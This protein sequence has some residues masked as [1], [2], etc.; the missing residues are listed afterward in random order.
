[1]E[2]L[3]KSHHDG[4]RRHRSE[5]VSL[6][7][8]ENQDKFKIYTELPPE[9]LRRPDVRI[10]VDYPEDLVVCRAV[11]EHFK[12]FA[13]NI[14]LLNVV[15]FLDKNKQLIKLTSSFCEDGYQKMYQ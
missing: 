3:K 15:N 2:A 6:F 7:I 8:H 13:P 12:E 4:D 11:Y 5:L 1:M 14:P 9:E 10:T